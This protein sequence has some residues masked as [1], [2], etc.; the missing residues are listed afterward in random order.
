MNRGA[1]ENWFESPHVRTGVWLNYE[2]KTELF[3]FSKHNSQ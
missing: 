1:K 3:N 2:E